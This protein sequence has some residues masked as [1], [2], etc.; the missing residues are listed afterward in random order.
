MTDT[1]TQ[2]ISGPAGWGHFLAALAPRLPRIVAATAVVMFTAF[3]AIQFIP[4]TFQASLA[5][6]LPAGGTP[7]SEAD[8]LTDQQHLADVVSRLSPE[9]VAEL[10][11]DGGGT[12]DTTTLLRKRLVLT[13]ADDDTHLN[14][15]ALAAT[16]TRARAILDA[17]TAGY[18]SLAAIPPALSAPEL[19]KPAAINSQVAPAVAGSEANGPKLLQERLSLAWEDRI[20]LESRTR[21]IESLIADGNYAM[22]ALDAENLPGL[23]RTLDSLATLQSER[24][25]LAV[26]LLPNLPKMRTITTEIDRLTAD[27]SSGLQQLASLA[28]ADR[29]AARRL[30]DSLRDQLAAASAVVPAEVDTSVATGSIEGQAEPKVI[31]LPR[32]VRTDLVLGFSGGLAFFG[33][34]GLFAFLRSRRNRT[35]PEEAI[36]PVSMVATDKPTEHNWLETAELSDVDIAVTWSDEPQAPPPLDSARIVAI[37]GG[38]EIAVASRK[39]LARYESQRRS[40]VLVDAASRRRGHV[41]GISDLS[42]GLASFADIVHGSG[43]HQVALVPWGRQAQLDPGAKS[44]RILIQALAEIYDVV[45]L[46][47]DSENLA[48][49]APLTALSDLTIDAG[50]VRD[51]QSV[52]A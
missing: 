42:L 20:R 38:R 16:P 28:K 15:A 30:E 52:A 21:R 1:S 7:A 41:P 35:G 8:K 31:A 6:S 47:L 45:I 46:S 14:L 4:Q 50:T 17:V 27:L 32:P 2:Q 26:D 39:L 33:Q 29:D 34:I 3:A 23:G 22:L 11:R 44:V 12:L 10:R 13:P 24:D 25:R 49:T 37:Q 5:L 51:D 36:E 18:A 48:A 43:A 9:I 19:A 40:V